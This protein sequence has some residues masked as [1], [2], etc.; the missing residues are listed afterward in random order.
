MTP[1]KINNLL[2][3]TNNQTLAD[4]FSIFERSLVSESETWIKQV[5]AKAKQLKRPKVVLIAVLLED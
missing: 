1:T 3:Q 4:E 5:Q 2:R